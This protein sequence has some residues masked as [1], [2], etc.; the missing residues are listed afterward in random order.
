MSRIFGNNGTISGNGVFTQ[1]IRPPQPTILATDF[2]FQY[3]LQQHINMELH[4]HYLDRNCL[5]VG[6]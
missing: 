5:L 1:I 3:Q 2:I 6:N 4:I